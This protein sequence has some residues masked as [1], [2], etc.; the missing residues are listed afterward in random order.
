MRHLTI[1]QLIGLASI[2]TTNDISYLPKPNQVSVVI[3]DMIAPPEV[4]PTA[5]ILAFTENGDVV[6]TDNVKRGPEACGGHRDPILDEDGVTVIRMETAAEAAEREGGEEAGVILKS[7]RPLGIFRSLTG[8]EKPEGYRY[9]HPWSTQQFFMGIVDRFDLSLVKLNECHGPVIV[10][11]EDAE[12]MLGAR[13]FVL[14]KHAMA[15]LFPDLA[16]EHGF[17]E[18]AGTPHP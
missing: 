10:K 3:S 6:L 9:P 14:Y 8:A 16:V 18:N 2:H 15:T 1:E 11:P 17:V 4:N 5:F 12:R 7:I 13:E